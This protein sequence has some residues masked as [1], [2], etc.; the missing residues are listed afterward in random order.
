MTVFAE[1]ALSRFPESVSVGVKIER[2]QSQWIGIGVSFGKN[3]YKHGSK[4]H[5]LV[6]SNNWLLS[7]GP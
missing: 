2:I 6:T 7:P 5:I 1:P 3:Q 4:S